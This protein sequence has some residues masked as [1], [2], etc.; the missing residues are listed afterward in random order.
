MKRIPKKTTAVVAETSS[1]ATSKSN[2]EQPTMS[3]PAATGEK[4]QPIK[5]DGGIRVTVDQLDHLMNLVGELVLARNQILQVF[6]SSQ[7]QGL[8]AASQRIN[9]ITSELQESV[10]KTR[11]QPIGNLW[12]KYP[13]VVRDVAHELGKSVRLEMEGQSTELDRTLIDAIRDPMIHIIRN[14]IDH[15]IETPEERERKGKPAEGLLCL[16]AYHEGGQV[17]I[18]ISDNGGGINIEK[19]KAKVIKEG[20]A[21]SADLES[22]SDR[23]IQQFIFQPGLTTT[24]KVT[25]VSGRGVGMDVVKT[26]IEKVGGNIEVQSES[27][28]GTSLKL[29]IPLT[30]A[31]IPALMVKSGGERFAIPQMSLLEL[32]RL[33]GNEVN[34]I[35]KLFNV[36]VFR[37][38]EHLLPLISLNEQLQLDTDRDHFKPSESGTINIIVVQA[39]GK[40]FGLILDEVQ[41]TEEIVVKPLGPQLKH[42]RSY[43]GATIMG[44]GRVAL[45]LDILGLA[46]ESNILSTARG[47]HN[48][49]TNNDN[50]MISL[51]QEHLL[52]FKVGSNG[53]LAIPL[54][55]ISRLEELPRDCIEIVRNRHLV[56]YREQILPLVKLS[57]HLPG[58]MDYSE[59][60]S[61]MI[62][63]LVYTTGS[64][65]LGIVVDEI[66]DIV[67]TEM[68]YS[69]SAED[70]YILGTIVVKDN[71][72]EVLDISKMIDQTQIKELL[73]SA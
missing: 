21:G 69:S 44:D 14:S 55:Q 24:A 59:E 6:S 58:V 3:K 9:T 33:E 35:E 64:Q 5:G 65:R 2:T 30:L 54:D 17:N 8:Q 53:R 63:V 34:N 72:T 11:M 45:I 23:D 42:L 71:V 61:E 29:K 46:E 73:L 32:V 15:G 18:E 49:D 12:T 7:E 67:E 26:N 43:A 38:R 40:P 70:S 31:I 62:Q 37:L 22:M 13:R 20:L 51:N 60:E 16:K 10:M 27:G 1:Q 52:V 25:N 4:A 41:D 57:D 28:E 66:I 39:D 50:K 47:S 56:Q 48:I 19:V 36:H 68:D